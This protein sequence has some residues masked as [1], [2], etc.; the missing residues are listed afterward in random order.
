MKTLAGFLLV[1]LL[2]PV[3]F[4][5][6]DNVL[7]KETG[8]EGIIV[9]KENAPEFIRYR[10]EADQEVEGLFWTPSSGQV[11]EA[12]SRLPDYLRGAARTGR[13]AGLWKRLSFYR[14][15]YVGL[16]LFGRKQIWMNFF[17]KR[18]PEDLNYS[19]WKETVVQ[20]PGRGD[21]FFNVQYDVEAKSFSDLKINKETP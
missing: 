17:P 14:R 12:E 18:L 13:S 10:P 8:A 2:S 19:P 15:Q 4:A 7:F 3:A 5:R 9:A 16:N 6:T 20:V 1:M 11:L 21:A